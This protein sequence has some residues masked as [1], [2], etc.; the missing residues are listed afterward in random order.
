MPVVRELRDEVTSVKQ[1]MNKY[2]KA[3]VAV[4]GAVITV[5]TVVSSGG[6]WS[7]VDWVAVVVP[8]LTALGVYVTPNKTADDALVE[9]TEPEPGDL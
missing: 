2:A 8:V 9:V 6:G 3:V 5:V 1:P 4:L 7:A